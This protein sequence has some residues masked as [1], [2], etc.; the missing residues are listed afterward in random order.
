MSSERSD[1]GN[2]TK[3]SSTEVEE[4][5]VKAAGESPLEIGRESQLF[6]DDYLV[7]SK[8]AF[9]R[10]LGRP[11]KEREPFLVPERSWEGQSALYGSIIERDGG[12]WLYYKAKN[13]T[14]E[15]DQE[16]FRDRYGFGKTPLCVA[17]SDD[18]I[19][20]RKAALPGAVHPGTNIVLDD[21]VDCAGIVRDER[22][23]NPQRRY[24][25]VACRG[26]EW[27]TGLTTATSGDGVCWTWGKPNELTGF[28]DRCAYWYNPLRGTHVA[29]SRCMAIVRKRVIAEKETEDFS[30]WSDPVVS[31]PRIAMMPDRHD[32]PETQFYGGYAFWYRSLFLAYIEV[33]YVHQQRLDTQLAASRDGREWVRLCEREVFLPNGEHGDFDAYWI[34]PT[35][36]PPI[37]TEGKLLI[38]FNGRDVPHKI[39][40]FAHVS[41]GM[42]GAFGL[43]SLREDGFVSLDATGAT[44]RLETKPLTLPGASAVLEVNVEP[45]TKRAGFDPMHVEV[46]I[47]DEF[48]RTLGS[49]RIASPGGEERVWQRIEPDFALPET[50][51]LRFRLRNARL[52]SFRFP[53]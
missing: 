16:A 35:F 4:I 8:R 9:M 41:P 13:W 7:S 17:V 6:V 36:N 28:G 44:G 53:E 49:W 12:Y 26:K 10:R 23:A 30:D 50:V 51:R 31:H 42:Y 46:D 37:L 2:V 22:E 48:G 19:H 21:V 40:G 39:P 24:K 52:Y 25:M 45:F 38:H 1:G 18:A 15:Y 43:S 33:Y 47:A 14:T 29:W 5:S 34:V 32:H 3:I 20:F 11:Q 27:R